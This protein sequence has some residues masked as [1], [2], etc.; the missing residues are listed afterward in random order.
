MITLVGFGLELEQ[1]WITFCVFFVHLGIGSFLFL[2]S[3]ALTVVFVNWSGKGSYKV[4][5]FVLCA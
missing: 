3:C 1:E 2:L 4:K 5:Y